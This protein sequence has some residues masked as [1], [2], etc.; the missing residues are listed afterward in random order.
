MDMANVTV[1]EEDW[2][3][4]CEEG[5][6]LDQPAVRL[7][8]IV[9]YLLVFTVCLLG[10]VFTIVVIVLHPTMRTG[11][12]YFLA[13]L[14]LADLLV[15]AFCI[16]QNMVH[17]V[18][19][20]HGNW[21]LGEAMCYIYVFMLH[22]IPC[23]SV[24][25][26]VCVSIEKYLVFMH[27]FSAWTR[28]I[29]RRRVRFLMTAATWLLSIAS[30]IPYP[31]NTRLYRF[32]DT[33]AACGRTDTLRVWV[34]VSFVLWYILPL[35]VL[36][37]MYTN[38]GMMLWRSGSCVIT[39]TRPSADSQSSAQ[40]GVS[41]QMANGRTIV[42][43]QDS[44]LQVPDDPQVKKRQRDLT[45]SRRKVQYR[46]PALRYYDSAT[47]A[48]MWSDTPQCNNDW[49]ILLQPL[50]YIFL[51]LSS[52][53]NPILY[54]FLSKRFREAASDIFYCKKGFLSHLNRSRSRT[55]TIVS[56]LPEDSR[57]LNPQPIT[58]RMSRL[59]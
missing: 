53:I 26:L 17:I 51:F 14:A 52:A 34:T 24:G 43:K 30:N 15:A 56:D 33:A 13:N 47:P 55:R 58:I 35:T 29:L 50:S 44:L 54:A 36:A 21:T 37:L 16:L 1:R 59:R 45:E 48:W 11:T 22:F 31:L 41:W 38:I 3:D 7:P 20:D 2:I 6:L 49:S 9:V 4:M 46:P 28:Q 18:G 12:N 40:T 27:P 19:F 39:V 23:L 42:Y 57:G 25:I 5:S 8:L 32:S 10:N